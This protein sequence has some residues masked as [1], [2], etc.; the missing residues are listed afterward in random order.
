MNAFIVQLNNRPGEIARVAEALS[1]RGINILVYG[2]GGGRAEGP[3]AF[4]PNDEEGS[5]STLREAGIAYHEVP[6][7]T[8]SMEDKPGQT[9]SASRRLAHAG[10]NIEL[11]LPVDTNP[12]SFK[13]ALGV[14]NVEAARKALREQLTTWSYR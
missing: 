4:I 8:V 11:W 5:R 10:V 2:L 3:I 13:V 14:D 1:A 9:A 7:I 12:S 6:V